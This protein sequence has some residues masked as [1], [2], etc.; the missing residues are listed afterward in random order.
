MPGDVGFGLA[1]AAVVA[2]RR[3]RDEGLDAAAGGLKERICNEFARAA[4]ELPTV[5]E[6][7]DP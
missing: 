1:Q 5:N 7:R 3:P 2:L 6:A 4:G